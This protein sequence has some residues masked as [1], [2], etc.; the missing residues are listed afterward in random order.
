MSVKRSY[1][2]N[3]NIKDVFFFFPSCRES[4]AE[5]TEARQGSPPIS[6]IPA[7]V[8]HEVRSGQ[9]S[10]ESLDSRLCVINPSQDRGREAMAG[11]PFNARFNEN[12]I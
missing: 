11:H 5:W 8:E 9:R 12:S 10:E 1:H 7:D 2:N 3:N 4:T 6:K